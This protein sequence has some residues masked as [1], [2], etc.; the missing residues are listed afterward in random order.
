MPVCAYCCVV[1]QLHARIVAYV[2]IARYCI[3]TLAVFFTRQAVV[4]SII[5]ISLAAIDIFGTQFGLLV[6]EIVRAFTRAFSVYDLE[7]W[8]QTGEAKA[9]W[10]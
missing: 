4:L 3:A 9:S 10:A 7:R 2:A 6:H 8:I 1:L 5:I